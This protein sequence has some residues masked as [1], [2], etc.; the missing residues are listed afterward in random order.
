MR[1]GA[2]LAV[3]ALLPAVA[4]GCGEDEPADRDSSAGPLLT[5]QRSGGIAFSV[6]SLEVEAD[7]RATYSSDDGPGPEEVRRFQLSAAELAGLQT[8]LEENPISSF[9]EPD[10]DVVCADCYEYELS[11]GGETYSASDA[12]VAADVK[13]LLADVR[14]IIAAYS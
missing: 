7:G 8:T 10:P 1:P 2:L 6:E 3:V 9:P 5:Y 13:P 4:I 12:T 14:E 11:Y